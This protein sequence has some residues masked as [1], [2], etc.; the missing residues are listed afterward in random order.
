MY[1]LAFSLALTI[2]SK[3][4]LAGEDPVLP[5][6]QSVDKDVVDVLTK[7]RATM[8]DRDTAYTFNPFTCA[9]CHSN[10]KGNTMPIFYGNSDFSKDQWEPAIG[11]IKTFKWE[12]VPEHEG[13]FKKGA[14]LID[15]IDKSY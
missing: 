4:A 8:S 7:R 3:I 1:A 5:T 13:I 12:K 14:S 9:G 6:V 15:L 11:T 10:W 2:T